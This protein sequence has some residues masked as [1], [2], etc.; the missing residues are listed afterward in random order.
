M[1]ELNFELLQEKI[2]ALLKKH[3]LT[4]N[5]LAEI[6]GMTQANVS[7]ALN[8]NESKQFTIDQ[9]FRIAQH[10]G[11]SI[12]ELVGN[13][14]VEKTAYSPRAVLAF[15]VELLKTDKA[16]VTTWINENEEV[17]DVCYDGHEPSCSHIYLN[18]E[19]P[20]IYFPSHF[21]FD[22][23][24]DYSTEEAQELYAEFSQCGNDTAFRDM[25]DIIKKLLPMIA[26]YKEK[27]IPEEAF[28][29]I[30]DGYLS[31]LRGI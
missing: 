24:V 11:V 18:V 17:F 14:A 12:D 5:A 20:A 1:S 30:V 28:Q 23:T 10:F 6:A 16:R 19:Y 25:N 29:M 7:K 8:R 26:L 31:Q 3:D 15:L 9:V 21:E 2:R 22:G 4:Q 27:E 13:K